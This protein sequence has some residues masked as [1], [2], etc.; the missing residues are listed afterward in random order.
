MLI[1]GVIS[2]D[3][4][5][6][7]ERMINSLLS[8]AGR[9]VSI[10]DSKVFKNLDI[11]RIKDYLHELENNDIDILIVKISVL[12]FEKDILKFLNFDVM[13]YANKADDFISID[14]EKYKSIMSTVFSLLDEKGIAIVNIDDSELV[15][16][17]KG[18]KHYLVTF[19][20]NSKA[21]ITTS[22]TG[23]VIDEDNLLC[24]LQRTISAKNGL[25]I[26]PQEYMIRVKT[27]ENNVYNV[28]AAA[29]FAIING[30]D[31]NLFN[32][33]EGKF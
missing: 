27:N 25:V 29:T 14:K 9:K 30:I 10:I 11:S 24:C 28:L 5:M 33:I 26:E 3:Q 23:D 31:L 16:F 1:A 6:H 17:I 15:Q 18:M 21:S 8:S 4:N 20:F 22:S 7:T 19:G 2:K 13:I 12:D 32:P